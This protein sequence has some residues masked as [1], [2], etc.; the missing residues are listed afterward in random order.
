MH[1]IVASPGLPL[2][3]SSSYHEI[4]LGNSLY[5]WCN[6][7]GDQQYATNWLHNGTLLA[8]GDH[9]VEITGGTGGHSELHVASVM[10]NSGG[11]Y[12][13]R[14]SSDTVSNEAF[15]VQILGESVIFPQIKHNSYYNC[16]VIMLVFLHTFFIATTITAVPP[17]PITNLKVVSV[18]ER[19][20]SLKWEM[21]FNGYTPILYT[22]VVVFS[23]DSALIMEQF[24]GN[25]GT[26]SGLKSFQKYTISVSVV[27]R[28]GP[29]DKVNETAYTSELV[30][31]L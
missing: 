14:V 6:T 17:A 29:S 30:L 3:C 4:E 28:V 20:I 22:K 12:T 2:S 25:S 23:E 27:N 5:L 18:N 7:T 8:N 26:I 31:Y 13:Y 21:G 19:S 10:R 11:T 15:T 1:F 9:G 24:E 16:V